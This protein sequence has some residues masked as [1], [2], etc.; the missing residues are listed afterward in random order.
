VG[1]AWSHPYAVVS[2]GHLTLGLHA[3][4]IDIPCL[5]YVLPE[6]A[7]KLEPFEARAITFTRV[8]LDPET[9]NE[10]MFRAPEPLDVRLIEARTF[11]PPQ[12][13]PGRQSACGYFV[14]LGVPAADFEAG[15]RFWEPLGFVAYE[16]QEQP[17]P[18]MSLTSDGIDLA[19]YRSRLLRHPMLTFEDTEMP[20]HLAQLRA[21]GFALSDEM[22]E[23]LDANANA[24]LTA[25]EG[26]RLL[27]L[28]A[29]D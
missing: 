11:S 17:F 3:A 26:T 22:P 25:P 9:F 2:D 24:V 14:E 6:L 4:G 19:F 7:R 10:V 18:R 1:E 15:A 5:T 27:L 12:I 23:A 21:R 8:Q 16:T 29:T 20:A 28:Q 13:E